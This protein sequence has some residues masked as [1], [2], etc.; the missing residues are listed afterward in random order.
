MRDAA[1]TVFE[2]II[3]KRALAFVCTCQSRRVTHQTELADDKLSAPA[4]LLLRLTEKC[5]IDIPAW[6]PPLPPPNIPG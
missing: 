6:S 3:S 4:S 2:R 1:V 5:C